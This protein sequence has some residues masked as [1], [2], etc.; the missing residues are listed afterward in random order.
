MMRLIPETNFDFI[1]KRWWGFGSS[2]F[3]LVVGLGSIAVRGG[4]RMGVEFTGGV[5]V[6]VE[7][8]STQLADIGRVRTA[9]A[10][11]GYDNRNIQR[12][13]GKDANVFL[14]GVQEAAMPG[15]APAAA[16][17]AVG[18]GGESATSPG[19]A[20]ATPGSTPAANPGGTADTG[21]G[22]TT[23]DRIVSAV[24]SE[25]VPDAVVLRS[26]DSVGPK[27]GSELRLAALQASLLAILLI[28]VYVAWR[29]DARFGAATVIAM[30]HDLLVTIGLFSLLNKEMTLTAIAAFLT[31]MGYSV[32]DTIVIFDRIRE[33]LKLK[34]RRESMES[35]FNAGMNKTLGRTLLTSVTTMF[36]LIALFVY[37][38]DVIHDFAWVLIVGIMV[39]TYSSVFVAAPLVIEW[40]RWRTARE[41][42]KAA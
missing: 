1:G 9:V 18:A 31:L 32:N 16:P 13:G 20:S 14:I 24:R 30:I 37:G 7:V 2:L 38:G 25:F 41:A 4:L 27:V 11:A 22:G 17:A 26:V 42:Q 10:K 29:F 19:G 33:E 15:P 34:Q 36:V 12:L 6:Q 40:H 28:L 23:S 21:P 3:L 5:Q 35:I 39:G 8:R